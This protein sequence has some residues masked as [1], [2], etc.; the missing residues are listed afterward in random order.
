MPK[1]T[2]TKRPASVAALY[3]QPASLRAILRPWRLKMFPTPRTVV[4]AITMMAQL[5]TLSADVFQGCQ[6][7]K[8]LSTMNAPKRKVRRRGTSRLIEPPVLQCPESRIALQRRPQES[9]AGEHLSRTRN[10]EDPQ[11]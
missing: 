11:D 3:A 6:T 2:I 9:P 4:K 7:T 10:G 5:L 1:K 8:L